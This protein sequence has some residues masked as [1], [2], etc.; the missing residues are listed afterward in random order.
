MRIRAI[1]TPVSKLTILSPT[2]SAE[3]ALELIEAKGFLS[4]PVAEER[5][6]IGFLSK[7]FIYETYFKETQLDFN[8]FLKRPVA[9][10]IHNRVACVNSNLLV[11]EAA[12]IFFNNKVRFL[13]V[14]NE[15]G[16]FIG[17]LTQKSLFGVITKVYGLKDPKLSILTDDFKGTLAKITEIISKNGGNITNIALFDTEVMGIQE[18][19]VR[20]TGQD[21]HVIAKKLEERGF[22]IREI[23]EGIVD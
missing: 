1:M 4:L 7:Q 21:I 14:V 22:K 5:R 12:D 8:D 11:E 3:K 17:I 15:L 18:I 20:I 9:H 6:F 2:D 23:V 10:F 19:S 16:E 13:P